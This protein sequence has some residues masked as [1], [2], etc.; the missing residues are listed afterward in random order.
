MGMLNIPCSF[1]LVHVPLGA[2]YNVKGDVSTQ[3]KNLKFL[4][5]TFIQDIVD[6][7]SVIAGFMLQNGPL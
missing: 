6:F 5:F 1:V 4:H 2:G 3:H 7:Q